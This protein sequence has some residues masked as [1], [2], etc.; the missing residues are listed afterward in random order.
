MTEASGLARAA[1]RSSKESAAAKELE[2][3]VDREPKSKL[4][5]EVLDEAFDAAIGADLPWGLNPKSV[6]KRPSKSFMMRTEK[7]R[8][9]ERERSGAVVSSAYGGSAGECGEGRASED[10]RN[11]TI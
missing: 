1:K 6:V 9:K 3:R 5:E 8:E 10:T 4:R 11:R 2:A 7:R